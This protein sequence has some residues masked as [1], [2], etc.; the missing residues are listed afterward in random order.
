MKIHQSTL[1]LILLTLAFSCTFSAEK[2]SDSKSQYLAYC[3]SCHLAPDPTKIP[4]I[5][6]QKSVLPEM[7]AR[8]GHKYLNYNALAGKSME[9]SMY[10]GLSGA[11]PDEP[12]TD[13]SS[14]RKI[15]EYILQL[16]PE[17]IPADSSRN[18]RNLPL[19]QFKPNFISLDSNRMTGIIS[20][21]FEEEKNRFTIGTRKGE[22]FKF[23]ASSVPNPRFSSPVVSQIQTK[24]GLFVTEIGY[25]N[26]SEK[27]VGT[28]YRLQKGKT[29]TL[30]QKL[31]RPVYTELFDADGDGTD[32]ILICEFGNYTGKLS[33]LS[34]SASS[35]EKK[36]LLPVPGTIKTEI[37][38]MD[39]D[40]N[41]DIV[42]AG[43]ARK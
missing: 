27:P 3:G 18:N 35:F 28:I 17:T 12:V 2:P 10:I 41:K 5:V 13:S 14:W 4:K 19:T 8:M 20:I 31:H 42:V 24:D 1:F 32:E 6:W 16:A 25:M 30:A 11:Y 40:G 22:I 21:Q 43:F 26:P 37:A 23:P 34:R 15:R 33:M 7:A 36:T 39:G 29:D 38:D 9:E